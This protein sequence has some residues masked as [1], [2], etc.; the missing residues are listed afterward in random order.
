MVCAVIVGGFIL[1]DS[2]C[3]KPT[4][5]PYLPSVTE[6]TDQDNGRKVEQIIKV[7]EPIP[8]NV[9]SV[10]IP[11]NIIAAMNNK[12]SAESIE[13]RLCLSGK[14]YKDGLLITSFVEPKYNQ[15]TPTYVNAVDCASA[16]IGF[17]HSH[18]KGNCYASALDIS[19]L[20]EQSNPIQGIIGGR[21]RF[22]F[23]TPSSP[24]TTIKV[25]SVTIG[26]NNNV[27]AQKEITLSN[28]C[29]PGYSL[30]NGECYSGCGPYQVWRCTPSGGMCDPDPNNCPPGEYSCNGK[31][32][33]G[34]TYQGVWRCTPNGGWCD[35]P[36][37]VSNCAK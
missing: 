4:K 21:D 5:P 29:E 9:Y 13:F 16:S 22:A 30:C 17:I 23:Y 15:R 33:R 35:C 10:Y 24:D 2:S 37:G 31:C 11:S 7:A 19:L 27:V 6:E 1:I 14:Q 36:P 18:P 28:L 25:Y 32:W 26:S 3:T 34:C 20:N 12:F 8:Q